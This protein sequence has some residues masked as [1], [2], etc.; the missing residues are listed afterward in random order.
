M[1][2]NKTTTYL[3]I[4][5][6]AFLYQE[7]DRTPMSIASVQI[8]EL[9][10]GTTTEH[11]IEGLKQVLTERLD[12]VP[13]LTRKLSTP[14]S[15]WDQ[16][17]WETTTD[18]DINRHVYAVQVNAPGA[19]ADIEKAIEE[20][21]ETP[22]DRSQPLWDY[23]VLHGLANGRIAYY[24]RIHH[25][26]ADGMAGQLATQQLMDTNIDA[27]LPTGDSRAADALLANSVA[28]SNAELWINMMERFTLSALDLAT[29]AIQAPGNIAALA[30]QALDPAGGLGAVMQS[31]P[32][33]DFN[34][35]VR[36]HR[37]FAM[38]E[39]P[40]RDVRATAKATGTTINDVF[41]S[42]C[43][44][45]LRRYLGRQNSLPKAPL[46][47]GC[48]I[49]LRKASQKTMNNAVSMMQVDLAT[50]YADPQQRLQQIA[51]SS[52][53]GKGVSQRL[54]PFMPSDLSMPG[55][56]GALRNLNQ[57]AE[58]LAA[59]GAVA[60]PIN[61]VIS[62]VPGPRKTLYSNGAKMLTHYPVSIPAHGIGL[63]IT[64]QSYVDGLYFSITCCDQAIAE[65][66]KLRDDMLA[67][68]AELC[69]ALPSS[70][71]TFSAPDRQ[72]KAKQ[73][74]TNAT[75]KVA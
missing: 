6:A 1:I 68:F 4:A 51:C 29:T 22:L 16:P 58:L 25:A 26:C 74:T 31:A 55:L 56:P 54:Q 17:R 50:D 18:F 14:T 47:A 73:L 48:P 15:T 3:N 11:F 44:G 67:A 8:L 63:N 46:I 43:S 71:A 23:A 53:L 33:T 72:T 52:K 24:A 38:G 59:S 37:G 2:S 7:T 10:K 34:K 60:T 70:V 32:A 20:L 42:V 13:Y 30:A 66:A 21:H 27:S 41:L 49:S 45:A 28:P 57:A 75:H 36:A 12:R 65:P 9:P 61:L 69:Q 64:V 62:N 5:D 19:Q 35:A 40:L 39:L